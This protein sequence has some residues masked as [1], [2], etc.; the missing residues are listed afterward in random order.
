MGISSDDRPMTCS[1]QWPLH[2][3]SYYEPYE[4]LAPKSLPAKLA[5]CGATQSEG[6]NVMP[7]SSL[8]SEREYHIPQPQSVAR[9]ANH[10]AQGLYRYTAGSP[11]G[12]IRRAIS[13]APQ[14][15]AWTVRLKPAR[16]K[17][18]FATDSLHT[19]VRSTT[20]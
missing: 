18:N 16:T 19:V 6:A 4:R 9:R 5:D 17:W 7:I 12:Q 14:P 20:C 2:T 15:G 10:E 1:W 13:I 8:S 3:N 11:S